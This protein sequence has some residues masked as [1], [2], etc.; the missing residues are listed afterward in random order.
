MITD[1][2][3]L[4]N[5]ASAAADLVVVGAG[6]A[7]I[8][9]ALEVASKGFD[10]L[11]VESGR[12]TFNPTIQELGDA[13]EWNRD[14][15]APMALATRRQ[16]GGAMAIW[17]GR[18]VPYDPV[19][20]DRRPFVEDASWPL[21]YED[22][23][24]YFG[25]AC[26]WLVCGRPIFDATETDHLPPTIVPGLRNEEAST[27]SLERWSLPTNFGKE[28][29][30]R[31][32]HAEHVQL[33]TGLTCTEIVSAADGPYVDHL[34]CRT[35]EGKQIRIRG[36]RYVV[37]CGGLETTRLLLAS[38]GPD[39]KAPGDHSGHLGRW[40]MGH[41]EGVIANIRFLTPPGKTIYG[42]ERDVDGVYVRRRLSFDRKFQ[43]EQ[44]LPNIVAW[45]A[46]PELAD[47]RHRSGALSFAY[48]ALISP[49]GR[50]FAPEA[51]RLSL[52][53]EKVPGAP[54]GGAYKGPVR[55]HLK[56]LVVD[57]GSTVRFVAGF[58]AKRFLARPRR[59]PGFFA[60]SRENVYP[61]Q[62]HGE[63]TPNKESRVT[64]AEERDALNMPKLRIDLRFSDEDVEGVI[65]AHRYWDEYVRRSGCGRIEYLHADL[66]EAISN[67]IGGGFH[68]IGTTRM[69]AR[70][71]DG[72][73]DR[74]LAVHGLSN[75]FVASSST[76][77]TSSQANSTFMIVVFSLR[78]AD[79]LCSV[80]RDP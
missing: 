41:V 74:D 8:V 79:H 62:Y 48:L 31:L 27:S 19:D 33:L 43:L 64:L 22:V 6:P 12:S 45:L 56:N 60:M 71:A 57:G 38:R 23:L 39:R 68:Q 50:F 65:R 32:Q 16:I 49:A 29:G 63:Q 69:A 21:S 20:F 4:E 70:P 80:L 18:C 9:I 2:S 75:L 47:P 42:Y 46:N 3:A 51:Q 37:A 40:Y 67:R 30:K 59:V 25:R 7:G 73:V 28:Y 15:H 1:A 54:Y 78:L 72:V 66:E 44:G 77:V 53:G 61:L 58:G 13:S 26:E 24:P 34:E 10:V 52:T 36:R 11:L 76:F 55:E 5:G 14:L 35:L 17:G